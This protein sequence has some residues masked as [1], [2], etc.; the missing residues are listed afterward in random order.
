M[1][2][3]GAPVTW[4]LS[5][6]LLLDGLPVPRLATLLALLHILRRMLVRVSDLVVAIAR[7]EI[8]VL[9]KALGVAHAV[10]EP[11]DGAVVAAPLVLCSAATEANVSSASEAP[12]R[13][14][15]TPKILT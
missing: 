13:G 1:A 9:R 3:P 11:C 15:E 5:A 6:A 8:A 2:G 7:V 10:V 12:Q 14:K 4:L